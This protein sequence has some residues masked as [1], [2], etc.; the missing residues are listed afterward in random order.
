VLS[1]SYPLLYTNI[2]A[3]YLKYSTDYPQKD[4]V[5]L[6]G[7]TTATTDTSGQGE[8]YAGVL[9]SMDT[10]A[11]SYQ[12]RFQKVTN[13]YYQTYQDSNAAHKTY[14]WA[15]EG[16]SRT[17][18]NIQSYHPAAL[19]E[20]GVCWIDPES[21]VDALHVHTPAGGDVTIRSSI[22]NCNFTTYC[23]QAYM[24]GWLF[25]VR[26][27]TDTTVVHAI[28]TVS[29]AAYNFT[30]MATMSGMDGASWELVVSYDETADKFYIYRYPTG[31][32][33][34]HQAIPNV[35]LTTMNAASTDSD[36]S[37]TSYTESTLTT[38]GTKMEKYSYDYWYRS[39]IKGS[40]TDGDT[41]YYITETTPYQNIYSFDWVTELQALFTTTSFDDTSDAYNYHFSIY[42]PTAAE[43]TADN[44][45]SS[46]SI[47]VRASGIKSVE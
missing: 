35:T 10:L 15:L 40:T 20:G 46:P 27:E 37:I 5:R 45:E 4:I 16:S 28:S 31:N 34:A 29:G 11:T 19:T 30:S 44:Y 39:T 26:V 25:W 1:T 17:T 8:L 38:Y 6:I 24:K 18:L 13:S 2:D 7:T 47:S 3:W 42:T 33:T 36:N 12:N 14:Y 32:N 9:A 43:I 22:P 21:N 23:R 41:V